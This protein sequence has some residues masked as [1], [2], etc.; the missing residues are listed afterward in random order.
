MPM[1]IIALGPCLWIG[2]DSNKG[3][4]AASRPNHRPTLALDYCCEIPFAPTKRGEISL[5]CWGRS[6][7]IT[8]TRKQPQR[9]TAL[10]SRNGRRIDRA[11]HAFSDNSRKTGFCPVGPDRQ[12]LRRLSLPI[13]VPSSFGLLAGLVGFQN[14]QH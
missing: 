9:G 2:L 14:P 12:T 13:H 1:T 4:E 11:A 8:A 5:Q 6:V 10:W 3:C 7:R